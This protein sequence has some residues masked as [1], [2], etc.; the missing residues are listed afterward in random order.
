MPRRLHIN[1]VSRAGFAGR[2]T[3]MLPAR[4]VLQA[5]VL[6]LLSLAAAAQPAPNAH[7]AGGVVVGGTASISQSANTTTIDQTTQRAAVNWRSFDVGSN[8]TVQFTQPN[9]NAATLNSVVGPNPSQIA[10]RIDANGQVVLVNQSGVTFYNGAQVNTAGLVV[11]AAGVSNMKKFINGGA[12][13]FD[14][15]GSPNAQINN[16]GMITIKEAGL[17]A[18]VAPSVV[19][20]GIINA[21]LGQVV[22]AGAKTATVDLIGDGLASLAVTGKVTQTPAPGGQTVA[23]LVTN[24]GV[25]RADGGTV[26]LT[27]RAADGVVQTLLQAS[28]KINANTVGSRTGEI[29]LNGVGGALVV[30]GVLSAQGNAAGTTG[31][32][33]EVDGPGDVVVNPTARI[34]ASGPGGGGVV[35]IGTTLARAEGGPS[36]TAAVTAADT[37]I[38]SGAQIAASATAAG[39]G[40]TVSVLSAGQTTMAGSLSAEGGSQS[41]NGGKVEVSG[42]TLSL[43]GQI[44]VTAPR[45]NTGTILLDPGGK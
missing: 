23:A 21:R 10:G 11:S 9:A 15:A 17:A 3:W 42:Q 25:I 24:S 32:N 2:A 14:Q 6:M 28:G 19:N 39:S 29:V 33:I 35:A 26:Q 12:L 22:L 13:G 41:G 36:V 18:L 45:G 30:D 31:G 7:P 34:N 27:A 8:E 16:A 5:A 44:D 38:A 20:S 40:G 4:V 37:T 1:H 43:T